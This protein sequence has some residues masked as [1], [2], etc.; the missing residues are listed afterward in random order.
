MRRTIHL[1]HKRHGKEV[2][3]QHNILRV[4]S[5]IITIMFPM[6]RDTCAYD[7]EGKHSKPTAYSAMKGLC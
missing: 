1:K 7:N 3:Q 5:V 4:Y 2:T 6:L